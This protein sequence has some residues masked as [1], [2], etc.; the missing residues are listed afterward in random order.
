MKTHILIAALAL[1]VSACASYDG[2][3]KSQYEDQQT[4]AEQF[5][6]N[7]GFANRVR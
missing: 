2:V 1:I 3:S 7:E 5:S 6:L 4:Q